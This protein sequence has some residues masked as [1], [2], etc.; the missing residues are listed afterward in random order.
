MKPQIV[1]VSTTQHNYP[2]VIGRGLIAVADTYLLANG[3]LRRVCILCDEALV[4]RYLEPLK[5]VLQNA[6]AEICCMIVPSGE[7][8]KSIEYVHKVTEKFLEFGIERQDRLICLGGGVIGDL[9]G[10]CAS[11]LLRGIPYIQ[12]PTTLLAQV[13]SSVGGK[14]GI[15]SLSGKNLIG[16]FYQPELVLSDLQMLDSLPHREFMAGYAEIVKYGVIGDEAF[17][18]YLENNIEGLKKRDDTI[19]AY[20]IE[21]SCRH[22]ATIVSQD[23]HEKN[24][25]ALL[26]LG[27][28]FGHAIEAICGY[29]NHIL[30][31]EAVALGMVLAARYSKRKELCQSCDVHRIETHLQ[32]AGFDIELH[33]YKKYIKDAAQIIQFMQKDKKNKTGRM[34][35][36]LLKSIGKSFM[37]DDVD[38]ED[39]HTFLQEQLT[40]TI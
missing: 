38:V 39:V 13:D 31:G 14:T 10:L 37:Y 34:R 11:L 24:I 21:Q 40:N 26:N 22:K 17:F 29:S 27:H 35:L 2:I 25:R 20:V 33:T 8:S 3:A 5:N 18:T 12:I 16:S 19:L 4:D 1:T 36:I 28:S 23:V 7:K 32:Q 9:G 15:N 30:H 6:G